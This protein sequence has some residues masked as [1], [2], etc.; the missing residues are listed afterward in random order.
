MG[1]KFETWNV[2]NLHRAGSVHQK[3]LRNMY[4][5]PHVVRVIISRGMRWAGHVAGMGEMRNAYKI[6]I[7]KPE[8]RKPLGRPKRGWKDNITMDLRKTG[9]ECVDWIHLYQDRDQWRAV[10]NTVMNLQVP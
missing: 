1:V 3:E 8:G 2:R 4:T 5:A 6:L 10:V 7:G 9:W